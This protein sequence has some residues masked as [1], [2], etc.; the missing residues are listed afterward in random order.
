[1]NLPIMLSSGLFVDGS[2]SKP[3]IAD[4]VKKYLN[5]FN[6]AGVNL[7]KEKPYIWP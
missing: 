4:V 6:K 2:T 7:R 5:K 1:M 3:N